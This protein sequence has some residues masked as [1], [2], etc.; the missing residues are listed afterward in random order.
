[1]GKGPLVRNALQALECR[2]SFRPQRHFFRLKARKYVDNVLGEIL[3]IDLKP[4]KSSP[5]KVAISRSGVRAACQ[6]PERSGLPWSRVTGAA[7]TP[8]VCLK[9]RLGPLGV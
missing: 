5:N 4:G 3:R 2:Y 8:V 6:T 9:A 7:D 1:M